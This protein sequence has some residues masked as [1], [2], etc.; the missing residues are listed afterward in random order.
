MIRFKQLTKTLFVAL[1]ILAIAASALAQKETPPEGGAPK[2][3]KFPAQDTYTLDNGLKVTLVKYGSVPKISAMLNIRSGKL[4]EMDGKSG[5]ASLTAKMLKEGSQDYT[6]EELANEIADIGGNLSTGAGLNSTSISGQS[7]AEFAPKLIELMAQVA[8]EPNFQE[9]SLNRLRDGELRQLALAKTQPR[10]QANEKFRKVFFGKHPYG[11][12]NPLEADLKSLTVEDLQEY[13]DDNFVSNRGHLYVVGQFDD[14]AVKN[15]IASAF[16]TWKSGT[17][18]KRNVPNVEAGYSLS[19]IDRP[20]APQSTIIMG[21]PAPSQSDEDFIKFKVMD[22]LLGGSF[23]SRITSNIRENKG[24]TYSPGSYV[25]GQYKTGY[26]VEQADVTTEA[27]GASIKEILYEIERLRNEP[28][29]EAEMNGI[30]NY[31]IGIYTLQNSSRFGVIGKLDEAEMH[32]LG[33]DSINDYVNKVANVT[34]KDVQ[35]MV[36]KYLNKDKMTIVVVG[37]RSKIDS[38]L[39]PYS[40]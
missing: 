12:I 9:D 4:N 3:F 29:T 39:K 21:V 36:K 8:L 38:Q 26:W 35:E 22:Q 40:K 25:W 33:V 13:F 31:M 34:G 37:D 19:V 14:Q 27:T 15:A 6:S 28:P 30:K 7:L 11:E 16:K 32:E 2:P 24:Y 23:G 17:P 20:G 18:M 10:S 5:V 1:G